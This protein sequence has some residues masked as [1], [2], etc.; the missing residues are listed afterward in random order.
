MWQRNEETPV[1]FR[2]FQSWHQHALFALSP[3]SYFLTVYRA[4]LPFSA[5]DSAIAEYPYRG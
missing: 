2:I 4:I 1:D 5:P 3:R